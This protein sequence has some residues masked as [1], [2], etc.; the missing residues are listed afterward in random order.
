MPPAPQPQASQGISKQ[1]QL[2]QKPKTTENTIQIFTAMSQRAL[3][4][5]QLII[6][7]KLPKLPF[8][9]SFSKVK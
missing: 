6:F 7:S 4:R 2:V 3:S 5:K 8:P 1:I 9:T